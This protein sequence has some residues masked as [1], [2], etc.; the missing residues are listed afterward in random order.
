MTTKLYLKFD[1][2]R[3]GYWDGVR[4][5]GVFTPKVDFAVVSCADL[6]NGI[7]DKHPGPGYL[8]KWSCY[9]LNFWFRCGSGRTWKEAAS[10]AKRKLQNMTDG[11]VE[12]FEE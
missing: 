5:S 8:I 10:I 1:K 6:I 7:R 4:G 2:P 9:P 3:R 12:V 11:T